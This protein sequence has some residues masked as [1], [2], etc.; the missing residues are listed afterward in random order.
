M[1]QV[2]IDAIGITV[3]IEDEDASFTEIQ[4][5]AMET[6]LAA[7]EKAVEIGHPDGEEG[8]DG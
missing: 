3:S 2:T 8:E 4:P 6:F 1:A 5:V 7:I